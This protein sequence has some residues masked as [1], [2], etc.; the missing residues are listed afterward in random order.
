MT[1]RTAHHSALILPILNEVKRLDVNG[2]K[3]DLKNLHI[4]DPIL[5]SPHSIYSDPLIYYALNI[6]CIELRQSQVVASMEDNDIACTVDRLKR[7][8]GMGRGRRVGRGSR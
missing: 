3:A 4:L 8:H 6:R 2:M 1:I 5:L 7:Q